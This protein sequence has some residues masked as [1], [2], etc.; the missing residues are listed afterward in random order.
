MGKDADY[1]VLQGI[2]ECTINSSNITNRNI[3]SRDKN[4][5]EC[6]KR[7]IHNERSEEQYGSK[8]KKEQE[9][10]FKEEPLEKQQ[11]KE[12][13][14]NGVSELNIITSNDSLPHNIDHNLKGNN[15]DS[16]LKLVIY[17]RLKQG[18]PRSTNF[19]SI[20]NINKCTNRI[21]SPEEEHNWSHPSTL[22]NHKFEVHNKGKTRKDQVDTF[23]ETPPNK[24]KQKI[25][26]GM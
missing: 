8:K 4:K 11:E 24:Q 1:H 12:E 3:T 14:I 18:I 21:S 6:F 5:E 7:V 26:H 19:H 15:A 10:S 22:D 25:V 20:D 9:G 13:D 23:E 16:G 17:Y 2:L